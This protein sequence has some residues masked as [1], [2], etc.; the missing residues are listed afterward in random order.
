MQ[1]NEIADSEDFPIPGDRSP[2]DENLITETFSFL[3]SNQQ[4]PCEKDRLEEAINPNSENCLDIDPMPFNEF[5]T[6]CLAS[7]AFP[8]LFPDGKGDP[9][10][11]ERVRNISEKETESFAQILKHLIKFGEKK[12]NGFIDLQDIQG[13]VIGLIICCIERE[14]YRDEIPSINWK[15]TILCKKYNRYKFLLVPSKRTT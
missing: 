3:S 9:T 14:F 15:N 8:T 1:H 10:N 6:S 2:C 7:L 13:L 4:Q 11:S 12:V 5:S